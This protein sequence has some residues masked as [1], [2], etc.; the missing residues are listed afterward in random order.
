MIRSSFAERN[1]HVLFPLPALAFD[2][3]AI[4]ADALA[5]L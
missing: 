2:H 3:D 5:M 1:L 4:V